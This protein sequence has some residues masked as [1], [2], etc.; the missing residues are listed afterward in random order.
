M[1]NFS[2]DQIIQS[3]ITGSIYDAREYV[4]DCG[5]DSSAKESVAA[6]FSDSRQYSQGQLR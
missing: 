1:D 4:G 5:Y 2:K 3:Q 6:R